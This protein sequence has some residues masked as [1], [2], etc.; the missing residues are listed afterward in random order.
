MTFGGSGGTAPGTYRVLR[1]S[2]YWSVLDTRTGRKI[3]DCGAEE[4]ALAL[5]A[6]DPAHRKATRSKHLAGPVVDVVSQ[7]LLPTSSPV[8]AP[9][10]AESGSVPV[11]SLPQ[12]ALVLTAD[13]REPVRV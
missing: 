13:G 12:G 11:S 7:P 1:H 9:A 5:V 6:F 2:N 8:P 4:D 3:A 10:S